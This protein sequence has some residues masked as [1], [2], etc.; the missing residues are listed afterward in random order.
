M[1]ETYAILADDSPNLSWANFEEYKENATNED[2][3]DAPRS[4]RGAL[5]EAGEKLSSL[6]RLQLVENSPRTYSPEVPP[7]SDPTWKYSADNPIFDEIFTPRDPLV[8]SPANT[9][10]RSTLASSPPAVS[11]PSRLTPRSGRSAPGSAQKVE[12]E[13]FPRSFPVQRPTEE[14]SGNTSGTAG[15][16][17]SHRRL[18]AAIADGGAAAVQSDAPVVRPGRRPG[19]GWWPTIVGISAVMM[20]LMAALVWTPDG[21]SPYMA[22]S[23]LVQ[24]WQGHI[25]TIENILFEL[26]SMNFVHTGPL[27]FWKPGDVL[28]IKAF[29]LNFTKSIDGGHSSVLVSHS[30]PT[31]ALAPVQPPEVFLSSSKPLAL[32]G[33]R[34]VGRLPGPRSL[35]LLH[36]IEG[37]E[38]VGFLGSGVRYFPAF[39]RL[40]AAGVG[41]V[42]L[43]LLLVHG[44]LWFTTRSSFA[45]PVVLNFPMT[46]PL[47]GG[48]VGRFRRDD[49]A[50]GEEVK[51]SSSGKRRPPLRVSADKATRMFLDLD[52]DAQPASATRRR[53]RRIRN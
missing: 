12:A 37:M 42:A 30:V 11:S 18:Q 41:G 53:S 29:L 32:F 5:D 6:E 52:D 3:M 17:L 48:R 36:R 19:R 34:A 50:D 10:V 51:G 20:L 7:V 4:V 9:P 43:A 13:A 1:T 28:A 15:W 38:D 35:Q 26:L 25:S 21:M 40:I 8:K 16:L 23:N 39:L 2:G 45:V 47:V 33:S 49:D 46:T 27:A 22:S 44:L 14:E 31:T 24:Q